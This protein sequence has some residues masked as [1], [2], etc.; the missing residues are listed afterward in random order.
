MKEIKAPL[1][2]YGSDRPWLFLAG[3]IEMGTAR[4]ELPKQPRRRWADPPPIREIPSRPPLGAP[5]GF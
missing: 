3:S 4:L 5:S 1:T 2:Y